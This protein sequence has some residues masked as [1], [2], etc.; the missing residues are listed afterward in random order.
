MNG[1]RDRVSPCAPTAASM[2]GRD[3]IV[4]AL[5]GAEEYGFGTAAVVA[6]GCDMARQCHLNT[7]PTGI[8]T[9]RADLRAKFRG[10]PEQI[11]NFLTLLAQEVRV[12]LA[13]LG[14]RSLDE[15]IGR[16]DLLVQRPPADD[17]HSRRLD[18]SAIVAPAD[19]TGTQ[20]LRR[21]KERND[22][23][24]DQPL[25]D[26]II[27]DA[28]AALDGLGPVHLAYAIR[29]SQRTVGA[30]LS[31][32]IARRYGNKGLPAETIRI[33]FHG[34][35]GQSFGAFLTPGVHLTLTGEANDYVGKGLGGGTIVVRPRPEARFAPHENVIVGN[36]V[37]YGATGG[38]LFVAGRAGERFGV[39]CSGARAVVEGCGDHGCEYMT[40]G[41]VVVLGPTGRNFAAGMTGGQAFVYDVNETF[42][43]RYNKELIS[44]SRL[45]GDAYEKYL[46][47]LIVEHW[48]KTGSPL[49]QMLLN[50]WEAQRLFFWHIMPRTTSCRSRQ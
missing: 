5:L 30:R 32:E 21:V 47:S 23:P 9:Q 42:E 6:I 8:A 25:D 50:D 7:C 13:S 22:R 27:R 38:E 31:G 39:R 15:I 4:A 46:K 36:T 49:A 34:S 40:E 10:R 44:I 14:A 11:V 45:Q 20:P 37:L 18:L 33:D 2:T 19:P 29:N 35:A 24:G 1:L 41:M 12:W 16:A 43:R 26:Q 3:V 17:H 48:E 28:A